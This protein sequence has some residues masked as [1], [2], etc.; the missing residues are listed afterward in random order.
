MMAGDARL[1]L[2]LT[3][4]M[5]VQSPRLFSMETL[6]LEALPS[7]V[8]IVDE[9]AEIMYINKVIACFCFR[10]EDC[11]STFRRILTTERRRHWICSE[12]SGLGFSED[13]FIGCFRN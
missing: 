1:R 8:L 10:I 9:Q 3:D 5:V 6:M 12:G 2:Y 7:P 13:R 4:M 11:F